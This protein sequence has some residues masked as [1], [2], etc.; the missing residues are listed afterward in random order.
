MSPILAMDLRDLGWSSECEC[1]L[2]AISSTRVA[3]HQRQDFA[4][5]RLA[6]RAFPRA[7]RICDLGL[8]RVSA[9]VETGM[10]TG[11]CAQ[12]GRSQAAVK[13]STQSGSLALTLGRTCKGSETRQ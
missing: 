4:Q 7:L 12:F 2:V 1:T 10:M 11:Q 8:K 13:P 5:R 3:I 6:H 9:R